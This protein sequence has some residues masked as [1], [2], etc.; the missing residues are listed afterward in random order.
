MLNLQ[1]ELKQYDL[2]A[3][4]KT[5]RIEEATKRLTALEN[6][7]EVAALQETKKLQTKIDKYDQ[8]YELWHELT[9]LVKYSLEYNDFSLEDEIRAAYAELVKLYKTYELEALFSGKYDENNAILTLHAGAG[10]T[11]AQD[12]CDILTRMYSLWAEK[13]NYKLEILNYL[14][15]EVAGIK[16]ITFQLSGDNAYG[17]LKNENGVHRLIRISPFDSAK[18]RHTSFVSVDVMPEVENDTSIVINPED[19]EMDTFRS[20]GAG[21]Q[22]VNKTESAV[23]LTHL[24]TGIIVTCQTERSQHQNRATAMKILK[25]K[26]V[27]LME[28]EH[29]EN[30]AELKGVKNDIAWGSQARTYTL[31]P[32]TL[33]KDHRVNY[34]SGNATKFLDGDINECLQKLL[35]GIKDF[36]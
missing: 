30:I 8:L 33:V 6:N 34:E 1:N 24:P 20:S 10:G 7:Y 36:L 9:G 11:E 21:G 15:G 3:L 25:G 17:W 22:H 5:M 26:L 32:Y 13:N 31:H 18:R 27:E 16:S 2:I 12:W 35:I 19:I 14:P 28:K 29:K 23:R 4:K